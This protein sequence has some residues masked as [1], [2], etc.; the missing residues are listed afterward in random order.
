MRFRF[1]LFFILFLS[2]AFLPLFATQGCIEGNEDVK[3]YNRKIGNF[4]H[5]Q[6]DGV[7]EVF[8]VFSS[9]PKLKIE[10][11]SNIEKNVES[12]VEKETLFITS[13]G[14]ICPKKDIKIYIEA[15]SLESVKEHGSST[16]NV[17]G[18]KEKNFS[19]FIDGASSFFVNG[20]AQ[21]FK[22]VANGS[23]Q[24]DAKL[25][26]TQKTTVQVSG[27]ADIK[28]YAT[29]SLDVLVDGVANITYFGNPKSLKR[30]GNGILDISS[31]N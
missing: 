16:I 27:T 8:V 17:S 1:S 7:Y 26:E 23:S 10:V 14:S 13:K 11:E 20:K 29:D 30:A 21:E 3:N 28:V 9:S 12:K 19:A 2:L 6:T 5:I 25:L 15:T 24:V 4:K 22:L 31:G 18:L